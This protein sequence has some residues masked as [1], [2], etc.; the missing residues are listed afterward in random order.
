MVG[1]VADP[2][3]VRRIDEALLPWRQ[4]DLALNEL[5]FVHVGDAAAEGEGLRALREIR[6]QATPHWDADRVELFFWF[7]QTEVPAT[8]A[9]EE[10]RV[11]WYR[12]WL[13]LV[14]PDDRFTSVE[15]R[16]ATLEDMTAADYV[17]SDPLDLDR[18]SSRGK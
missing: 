18:L 10:E 5:P 17:N 8:R 2:D 12:K 7:V 13:D 9:E 15:G 4:G 6:V 1:F 14:R 11:E 3:L 16:L